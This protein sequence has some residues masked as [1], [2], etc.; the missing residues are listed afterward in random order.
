[1]IP[2][3]FC[4]VSNIFETGQ[5]K[6]VRFFSLIYDK[7]YPKTLRWKMFRPNKQTIIHWQLL[8]TVNIDTV[9][10]LLLHIYQNKTFI[11]LEF[12]YK[13]INMQRRNT[14]IGNKIDWFFEIY[15]IGKKERKSNNLSERLQLICNFIQNRLH[16]VWTEVW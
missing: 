5:P 3:I 9:D 6:F 1:M 10:H 13:L 8:L 11:F 7:Y 15:K 14:N 12:L 16:F 2:A 4:L